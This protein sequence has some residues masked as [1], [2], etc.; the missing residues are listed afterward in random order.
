MLLRSKKYY[1]IGSFNLD[2]VY[3][4]KRVMDDDEKTICNGNDCIECKDNCVYRREGEDYEGS[5]Y[6][7]HQSKEYTHIAITDEE[8]GAVTSFFSTTPSPIST[9]P[10]ISMNILYSENGG[11]VEQT[12][13][14][15]QET[16]E[17]TLTVPSHGN[18]SSVDLIISPTKMVLSEP[19]HCQVSSVM[20][21]INVWDMPLR[22][23]EIASKTNNSIVGESEE[24]I[25]YGLQLNEGELSEEETEDFSQ[26]MKKKCENKK[27]VKTSVQEVDENTFGRLANGEIVE[28][29]PNSPVISP[30]CSNPK[31]FFRINQ[32]CKYSM[33]I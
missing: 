1:L 9:R 20:E 6:C 27:I 18:F 4:F 29:T 8:C 23:S 33:K 32:V 30:S 17:A 7:F 19:Y 14:F 5:E 3:S 28:I 15:D 22:A 13:S 26:A 11:L 21:N 31:V 25:V 16:D 24:R 10:P 2:G 12:N